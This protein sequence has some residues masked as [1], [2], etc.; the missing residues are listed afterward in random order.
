[1]VVLDDHVT[2]VHPDARYN[3]LVGNQRGEVACDIGATCLF[4]RRNPAA[5]Q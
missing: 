4:K 5:A 3:A 1:M 2:E